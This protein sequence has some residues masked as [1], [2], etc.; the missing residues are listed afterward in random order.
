M[1][2]IFYRAAPLAAFL[3][4]VAAAAIRLTAAPTP[5]VRPDPRDEVRKRAQAA[6]FVRDL[7]AVTAETRMAEIQ[8]V[9]AADSVA[10]RG[11]ERAT[12]IL[13]RRFEALAARRGEL[14]PDR[15]QAVLLENALEARQRY[16]RER[17]GVLSLSR[18][19]RADEAAAVLNSASRAAFEELDESLRH[20]ADVTRRDLENA[21]SSSAAEPRSGADPL[22]RA[23]AGLY[24]VGLVLLG[25]HLIVLRRRP[26]T[27][28]NPPN[29]FPGEVS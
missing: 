9:F 20:L 28:R 3:L 26:D 17:D 2:R 8:H 24:A 6:L 18:E 11:R 15:G 29:H 14:L 10:R 22:R 4:F 21:L 12:E 25:A 1:K 19:G 16:L 5:A 7:S 27:L 23:A 13:D